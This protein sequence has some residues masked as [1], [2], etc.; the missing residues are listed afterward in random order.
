MNKQ[1]ILNYALGLLGAG[2]SIIPVNTSGDRLKKPHF[3]A[4]HGTGHSR[5][6]WRE[7]QQRS[8]NVP[9]WQEFQTT[10]ATPEEVTAWVMRF[11]VEGFALVTGAISGIV[12]IDFDAEGMALLADL[13]W[14]A[15]VHT[16]SGGAHV[17]VRHPGFHVK[18]M[19]ASGIKDPSL[20]LPAGVDV[21]GDGGYIVLPPTVLEGRGRYV[22]T[23]ERAFLN[24]LSI[25]LSIMDG[26]RPCALRQVLGLTAPVLK[27][28]ALPTFSGSFQAQDGQPPVSPILARAAR[29][30]SNGSGRNE[31]GFYFAGQMRDNGYTQAEAL[32][33]YALLVSEF[34]ACDSHGVVS[35]YTQEEYAASVASAYRRPAR[36]MWTKTPSAQRFAR[37]A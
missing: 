30:A 25:P 34:P 33:A 18:T 17:Y 20:M 14:K 10:R 3:H 29:K 6:E 22:R 21:R 16:P 28:Q 7:A 31:A 5:Q 32:S 35:A 19:K 24:V 8:V 26:D 13:G 11:G 4:L 2:L 23:D 12:A 9:T 27:A 37:S 1:A 36:E 15:H